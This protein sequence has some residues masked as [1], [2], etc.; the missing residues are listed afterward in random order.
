M[1]SHPTQYHVARMLEDTEFVDTFMADN[2]ATLESQCAIVT[3]SLSSMG[4]PF[5]KPEVRVLFLSLKKPSL[6]HALVRKV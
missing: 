1:M 6:G 3:D 2:Q 5:V 4:I